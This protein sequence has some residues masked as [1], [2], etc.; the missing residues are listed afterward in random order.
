VTNGKKVKK[1]D[2]LATVKTA[3]GDQDIKA[4]ED[5]QIANL[6]ASVGDKQSDEDPLMVIL[7]TD[8]LKA[9]INV[10]E[11]ARDSF[12]EDDKVKITHKG[13]EYEGKV[14]NM[15]IVPDDTGLFPIEIEVKNDNNKILSGAVVELIQEEVLKKDTLKVPTE[16]I[17]NELDKNYL[18]LVENDQ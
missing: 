8:K 14:T 16:A 7:D 6:K 17:V 9:E 2:V 18:F 13:K 15:D 12:S 5:G 10:T 11:D 3:T 1:D 4:K